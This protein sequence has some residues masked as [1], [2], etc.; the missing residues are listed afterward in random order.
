MNKQAN[1][2]NTND[3]DVME[4][5]NDACSVVNRLHALANEANREGR[6]SFELSVKEATDMCRE[7]NYLLN[8]F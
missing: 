1:T 7:L 8:L 2:I 4:L 5:H 6:E 3:P